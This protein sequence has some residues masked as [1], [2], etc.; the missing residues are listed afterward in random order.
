MAVPAAVLDTHDGATNDRGSEAAWRST[1][2]IK[3]LPAGFVHEV[4]F[5]VY[6]SNFEKPA[7]CDFHTRIIN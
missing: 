7:G 3:I 2:T 1:K 4:Q 6:Y 5:H